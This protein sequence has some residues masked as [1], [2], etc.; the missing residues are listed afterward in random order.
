MRLAALAYVLDERISIRATSAL[1]LSLTINSE[2]SFLV[3][4]GGV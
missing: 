4:F 2:Y 1:T 3:L